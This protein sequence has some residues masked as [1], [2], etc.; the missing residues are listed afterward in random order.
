MSRLSLLVALV[1]ITAACSGPIAV[2]EDEPVQ[3]IPENLLQIVTTAGPPSGNRFFA[4]SGS[5]SE[6]PIV[7]ELDQNANWVVGA[8]IDAGTLW[9]VAF[10]DGTLN[11]YVEQGGSVESVDLNLTSLPQGT[12]PAL[13]VSA[14]GYLFLPR[15]RQPA[16]SL[17]IRSRWRKVASPL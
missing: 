10:E 17:R 13:L 2:R 11:G 5:I 8:R 16:R 7:V 9:V 6:G 4:G 1:V 3:D 14:S 12:P 15:L